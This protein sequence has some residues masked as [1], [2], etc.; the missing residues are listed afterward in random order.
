MV[1]LKDKNILDLKKTSILTFSFKGESSASLMLVQNIDDSKSIFE[2]IIDGYSNTRS[3]LRKN[4]ETK[5]TS[6]EKNLVSATEFRDFWLS[7]DGGNIKVGKG[8]DINRN[9]FMEWSDD[10]L[11]S[12]TDI[13]IHSVDGKEGFWSCVALKGIHCDKYF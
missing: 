4:G 5:I 1:S 2:I 7:W 11:D 9:V 12:L 3:L 10:S 6:F 13:V 8:W